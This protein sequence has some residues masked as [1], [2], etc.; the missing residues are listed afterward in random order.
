[1]VDLDSNPTKLLEIVEIGKQLLMTRGALTTFSI[2]NDVAKY[3]AIIPALFIGDLSP[4]RRAEHHAPAQ[5]AVGDALRG[6]LQRP[7]HRALIPL[8]L[9][10]VQLP[11]RPARPRSCAARLHLRSRRDHRAVHLH[12][13]NRHPP[14]RDGTVLMLA[15]LR[16]A[17]GVSLFFFVLL[18]L[19]YPIAETGIGQAFFGHRANGSLT[20]Y[21]SVL[22]GQTWQGPRWFQ[23]RP[24]ADNP[25]ATGGTNLGPVRRP[26]S[27]RCGNR[28]RGSRRRASRRLPISSPPR[29]AGSTRTSL[30]PT[31][32]P[33]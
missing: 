18:G 30:P 7:H 17:L 5:P 1:M 32:T 29:V 16:Q 15:N 20:S 33:R 6:D 14:H 11:A 19:A 26:W 23:G 12:Q 4:A 2:A 13:G 21:G 28:S 9:R 24:D 3:F 27:T 22:V 25:A 8:A 31:R 10:G